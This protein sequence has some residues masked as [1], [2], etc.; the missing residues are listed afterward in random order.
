MDQETRAVDVSPEAEPDIPSPATAS[1]VLRVALIAIGARLVL[2][3]IGIIAIIAVGASVRDN[4]L[5]LWSN[6]DAPHYLRIAQVGYRT[7]G[8]DSLLIVFF[9]LYPMLVRGVAL[10]VRNYLT[11]GL[12]I[13]LVAS[14]AAGTLLY[15]LVELDG[16]RHEAWRAVVLLF[17]FPTAYFL[18]AP[19]S[20]AL[21]LCLVLASVY[22]AR[23]RRDWLSSVTGALAGA[24]RMAGLALLPAHLVDAVRRRSLR[25]LAVAAAPATGFLVYLTINRI[26]FGSAFAFLRI[27][28]RHW[29][30]HLVPPWRPFAD[31]AAGVFLPELIRGWHFVFWGRLAAF[32]VAVTLLIAARH[33]LRPAENVY[34]WSGLLLVSCSSWLISLPRYLIGIYPVIVAAAWLARRRAIWLAVVTASCLAQGWLFTRYV[35]GL[36]AF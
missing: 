11:A 33:R 21:F 3:V 17:A 8:D 26:A 14:V 6:W 31:A 36:W 4:W 25:A 19:Y 20:E 30:Q 28:D 35:T 9:P 32:A 23:Q 5:S 27:Q 13:S 12:G 10:A 18:S 1:V 29:Y 16:D 7:H 22:L 2:E 24:T 15:R 34:A